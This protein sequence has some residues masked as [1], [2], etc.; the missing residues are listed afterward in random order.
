MNTTTPPGANLAPVLV[1]LVVWSPLAW[2]FGGHAPD[3]AIN[4]ARDFGP[5]SFQ[6]WSPWLSSNKW[7]ET[8]TELACSGF[9]VVAG[10]LLLEASVGAAIY[11]FGIRRFLRPS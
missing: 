1:G 3:S 8:S 6:P 5:R 9:R 10:P 2:S 7:P 4:P 11:D